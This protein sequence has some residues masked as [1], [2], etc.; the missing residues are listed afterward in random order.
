LGL[1]EAGKGSVGYRFCIYP[2]PFPP[3]R[4]GHSLETQ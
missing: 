2:Y 4:P 1:R 3:G